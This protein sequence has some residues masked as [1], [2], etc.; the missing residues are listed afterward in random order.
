MGNA[1]ASAEQIKDKGPETCD[2]LW[3]FEK[4]L[5]SLV[6]QTRFEILPSEVREVLISLKKNHPSFDK[7]QYHSL[8]LHKKLKRIFLV[9][10]YSI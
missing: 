9:L 5:N 2:S 1:N 6:M 8:L 3:A 4:F 10:I 7:N